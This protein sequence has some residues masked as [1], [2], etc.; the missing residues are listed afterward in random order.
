MLIMRARLIGFAHARIMLSWNA[1]NT[2]D[3]WHPAI[4]IYFPHALPAAARTPART[5]GPPRTGSTH[6]GLTPMSNAGRSQVAA[7]ATLELYSSSEKKHPPTTRP[8]DHPILSDQPETGRLPGRLPSSKR[9]CTEPKRTCSVS[10]KDSR[11]FQP[12]KVHAQSTTT[13]MHIAKGSVEI[14]SFTGNHSHY[15]ITSCSR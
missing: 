9:C 8:A 1:K 4:P 3:G 13:E 14:N 2:V 6:A 12:E 10:G 5:L 11:F 15:R 7:P